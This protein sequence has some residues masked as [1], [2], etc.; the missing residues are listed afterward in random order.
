MSAV[1][2]S[3]AMGVAMGPLAAPDATDRVAAA[4][5]R[6]MLSRSHLHQAVDMA[7][8]ENPTTA[9]GSKTGSAT[10]LAKGLATGWASGLATDALHQWWSKHPLRLV[11]DVTL[12][13]AKTLTD[14][15]IKPVA[16][17]HPVAVIAGAAAVGA[18]LV[19]SRPWRWLLAP[20]VLAS[21]LPKLLSQVLTTPATT[22]RSMS[23]P[24][25]KTSPKPFQPTSKEIT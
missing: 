20:A 3:P 15:V 21:V 8:A 24:Q 19:W 9:P 22:P 17:R 16:Q 14:T 7:K 4:S 12:D 23:M 2:L 1:I 13:A 11:S 5:H 10:G 6:L 25:R 18:L